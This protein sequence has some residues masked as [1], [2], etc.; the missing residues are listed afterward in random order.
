MRVAI[1]ILLSLMIFSCREDIVSDN[2][3]P[4]SEFNVFLDSIYN[5]ASEIY[6]WN[7][8]ISDYNYVKEKRISSSSEDESIQNDLF[9][10]TSNAINPITNKPYEYWN[11]TKLKYSFYVTN[12]LNNK[13]NEC[14][15]GVVFTSF[16]KNDIRIQY[17]INNSPA[18]RKGLRRGMRLISINDVVAKTDEKFYSYLN[19]QLSSDYVEMM[20]ETEGTSENIQLKIDKLSYDPILKDTILD[21]SNTKIGY[22]SYLSFQNSFLQM[23]RLSEIFFKYERARIDKLIIDLRY[24]QGGYVS[25]VDY[26]ANRL[27]PMDFD[28]SL[29]RY[30]EYNKI[31]QEG[32]ASMLENQNITTGMEGFTLYDYDY[33]INNNTIYFN[34]TETPIGVKQIV[35]IISNITASASELLIN[36]LKPY[37]PITIIGVNSG[38][39]EAVY[40][41]GKP[42]GSI[43]INISNYTF[44]LPMFKNYNAIGN[45][46]YF[47]GIKADY[48]I[49]DDLK[50]DFGESSELSIQKS[51]EIFKLINQSRIIYVDS[52]SFEIKTIN[53]L[54][55]PSVLIKDN[56]REQ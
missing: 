45:G 48:S 29:M 20:F 47:N 7:D 56:Y 12:I 2:I 13:E 27:I 42:V 18:Q 5:Y 22:I 1:S 53:T 40:S 26:I 14:G 25:T 32:Q 16:K 33:S 35:F 54:K 43:G 24:N 49:L 23:K 9:N 46:D 10:I 15:Y 21:L 30:E 52:N 44:Y 8:L 38:N 31:M 4:D 41:Y 39:S 34:K 55:L 19:N 3:P 36:V 11:N 37:M 28:G 50:H 6:Y 17:V 51:L